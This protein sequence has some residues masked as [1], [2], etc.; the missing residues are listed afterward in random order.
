MGFLRRVLEPSGYI[1]TRLNVQIFDILPTECM[2]VF[3]INLRTEAVIS[4]H[5]INWMIF[6]TQ[7]ECVYYAVRTEP[8]NII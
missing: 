7:T 3:Y 1:T 8:S 5:N 4:Q 2:Y 6:I